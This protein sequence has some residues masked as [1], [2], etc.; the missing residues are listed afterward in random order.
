VVGAS[1]VDCAGAPSGAVCKHAVVHCGDLPDLGVTLATV[2]PM[3]P[4]AT[5]LAL[6]GGGGTDFYGPARAALL[7]TNKF[8][9]VL[10][11]WDT[12]WEQTPSSGIRAAGCRPATLMQWVFDT[13]HNK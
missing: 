11:K 3:A 2:T 10:A 7:A 8:R 13:I 1:D 4:V 12:D 5:V 6:S 9:L